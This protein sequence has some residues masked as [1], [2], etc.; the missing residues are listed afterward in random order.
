MSVWMW[1]I[2]WR[3]G[4]T[5]E[6]VF[7]VTWGSILGFAALSFAVIAIVAIATERKKHKGGK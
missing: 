3:A 4:L 7:L 5:M 6:E 1:L 2:Y